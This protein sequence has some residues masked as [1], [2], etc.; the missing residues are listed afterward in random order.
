MINLSRDEL[1]TKYLGFFESKHHKVISGKSLVPENDPTVLFTTAGMHPLVPYI[2]GEEHPIG[3]R[4]TNVQKC[5]RTGD[6]DE[7]G[8]ATHLTF[9]EML[10]NWSLGDYF[11]KE[12]LSMS[13]E[14]LTEVLKINKA[15][16]CVSVFGG[17]AGIERDNESFQIWKELGM[18]EERI[19]FFG[20]EDNFWG[21]AGKTGPCG[22]DSEIFYYIKDVDKMPLSSPKDDSNWVEIWNN[23]FMEYEKDIN[24]NYKPLSRKCVDTGMGVERTILALQGKNDVYQTEVFY[25]IIKKLEEL[26]GKKYEKD[27]MSAMRIIADHIR[28]SVFILG[29]GKSITPSNLG[30]GYILRRLLRRAILY[31][32]KLGIQKSLC[33]LSP[34]V[35]DSYKNFYDE[36]ELKKDYIE[37]EIKEEEDRFSRTIVYG[38][39]EF[40][41]VVLKAENKTIDAKTLF[42]LYDTYGFPLE[43]SREM[44]F[45]NG[46]QVDEAGFYEEFSKHKEISKSEDGVFKGGLQDSS[47]ETT[48]LHTATHLLH[49][50]LRRVLGHHV[51]QRG[52]NI[53]KE[54]LRFDFTHENK[55][56]AE[57]IKQVEDLVNQAINMDLEVYFKT[58]T[59]EEAKLI[60]ARAFF[61]SK[62]NEMVKVYFIGD[63]SIEV[64]G[65]PHVK[66]TSEL[67]IFK[68]EK[69]QSSSSGVRRI[70]AVLL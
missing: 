26:S 19:F 51:V 3:K 58:M 50:A 14:F 55:M 63:F 70:K 68:I 41:K 10:G 62:Y 65:G 47:V 49:E 38:K 5:I 45:A 42:K 17:E 12:S 37:M 52:S 46:M 40:D 39:K 18:P 15:R 64:C 30:Q 53:T 4:L 69:E 1:V 21:P 2:L 59:L 33:E 57:E 7:V 43:L 34:I 35:I 22:R 60:G 24:G 36:L 11:K 66:R 23:V 16:L 31:Y 67:G 32:K 48:R 28:S 13:F 6:I 9:F 54:R 61:D 27:N 25:P 56:S 44:A 8:D 29:D 20:K